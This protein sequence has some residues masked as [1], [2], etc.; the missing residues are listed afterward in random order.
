MPE[1]NEVVISLQV[2]YPNRLTGK[3]DVAYE[4]IE[5]TEEDLIKNKAGI[6]AELVNRLDINGHSSTAK[7]LKPQFMADKIKITDLKPLGLLEW[8]IENMMR[9]DPLSAVPSSRNQNIRILK[10]I[11]WRCQTHPSEYRQFG[12]SFNISEGHRWINHTGPN[13]GQYLC[14]YREEQFDEFLRSSIFIQ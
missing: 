3:W 14:E 6:T 5:A 1:G 4:V 8:N 7:L 11:P 13:K 10:N 2:M 12:L 9:I